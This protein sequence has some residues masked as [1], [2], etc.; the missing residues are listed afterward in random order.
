MLVHKIFHLF[1]ATICGSSHLSSKADNFVGDK[2]ESDKTRRSARVGD[3]KDREI[4][5]K[6]R[7]KGADQNCSS[8]NNN[9]QKETMLGTDL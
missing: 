3:I 4:V 9:E 7:P 2:S 1:L 5:Q 6:V 8:I